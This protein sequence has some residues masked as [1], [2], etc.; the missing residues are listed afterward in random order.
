MKNLCKWIWGNG[1]EKF[2]TQFSV[3]GDILLEAFWGRGEWIIRENLERFWRN[4]W[5]SGNLSHAVDK[6]SVIHIKHFVTTEKKHKKPQ[7]KWVKERI[8][9]SRRRSNQLTQSFFREFLMFIMTKC[10]FRIVHLV[11]KF[12]VRPGSNSMSH[13]RR[14]LWPMVVAL[15]T[16]AC[17][18]WLDQRWAAMWQGR[19]L[20]WTPPAERKAKKNSFKGSQK[21]WKKFEVKSLKRKFC[22]QNRQR[23]NT[24]Q[25]SCWTSAGSISLFVVTGT[26]LNEGK[27][28]Q[29]YVNARQNFLFLC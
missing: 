14:D 25:I 23:K 2:L 5:L 12:A 4:K 10:S 7:Q 20:R 8:F 28:E 19:R 11:C 17:L 9:T 27:L 18:R 22:S 6:A 3:H 24:H 29:I 15:R 1:K 13:W 16:R 26:M 21:N